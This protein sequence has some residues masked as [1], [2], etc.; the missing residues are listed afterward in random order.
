MSSND[1][2]GAQ[3]IRFNTVSWSGTNGAIW[4]DGSNLKGKSSSGGTFTID[5]SSSGPGLA[6]NNIWTGTNTFNGNL[7]T[8]SYTSLGNQLSDVIDI[9]GILRHGPSTTGLGFFGAPSASQQSLPSLPS[10]VQI[11]SLLQ[12]Y[13]LCS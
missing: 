13:G 11:K 3:S 9:T 2:L 10:T 7:Y 1:V 4:Y 6:S 12:A 8:T 5:G